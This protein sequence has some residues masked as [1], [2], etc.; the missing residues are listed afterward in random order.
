MGISKDE[1]DREK[2]ASVMAHLAEVLRQ[3]GIMLMPFLT[4]APSKMF[5]QL[6]LTDEAHKSWESL[7]TIGCIPA[8]TK[9]EKGN[10]IFPRLEMEVEVEYIKEQM[11]SSAPKVEEKKKKNRRQ[12]KLQL[13]ISL[14]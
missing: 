5:A 2:L 6:G 11:K 4:V 9:V 3:T 10:P 8:G 1:N 12:K 7:S 13:M 14:K